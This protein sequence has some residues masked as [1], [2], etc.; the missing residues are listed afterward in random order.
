MNIID[1]EQI[2]KSIA[3][4]LGL[5]NV[6]IRIDVAPAG[7]GMTAVF[8]GMKL[9]PLRETPEFTV[10]AFHRETADD[11][12]ERAELVRRKAKAIRTAMAAL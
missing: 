5:D 8:H 1:A 6:N 9:P 4:V 2:L 12:D 3:S 7:D 11:L 10:S